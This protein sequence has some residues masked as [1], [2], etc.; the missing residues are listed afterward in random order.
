MN[1]IMLVK[2]SIIMRMSVIS[3]QQ[4]QQR[5]EEQDEERRRKEAEDDAAKKQ[6]KKAAQKC[7]GS[8]QTL[9]GF[10]GVSSGGKRL[11]ESTVAASVRFNK[12]LEDKRKDQKK[13][14]RTSFINKVHFKLILNLNFKFV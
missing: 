10:P 4:K 2:Q 14:V 3:L 13:K 7:V 1:C 8:N 6:K 12:E 9:K 11:L 5:V